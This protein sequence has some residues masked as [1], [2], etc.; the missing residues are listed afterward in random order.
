MQQAERLVTILELVST[1][2]A[3]DVRELA[4]RFDVSQA[5][6]RRDL[7]LLEEQ[8]LLRRSHGG[9]YAADVT[10]EL[11]L[12]YR[13]ERHHE[14]KRRIAAAAVDRLTDRM[15]V[16]F[17]GGTTTTEVARSIAGLRAL[18]IVT[19]A[20]NIAGEL[21]M[22]SDLTLV[23]TG[24]TARPESYE[25]VGPVAEQQLS[26]LN[27]DVAFIG[28]DGL[29]VNAGLTT[30]QEVEAH[31]NRTMIERARTV[32]VVA[33]GSKLGRAAFARICDIDAVDEVITDASAAM[34][35]VAGLRDAG[36]TVTLV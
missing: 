17:T 12:R 14:Q 24:G 11:P 22:R 18:T 34:E 3:V 9:A 31:T 36:L 6:V 15:V 1:R 8:R 30:H 21:A 13:A 2:N 20:L 25:L 35:S 16:G 32:I 10:L 7:G 28:V 5:T 4:R 19:N 29:A 26:R 23:V 33:D 27:L